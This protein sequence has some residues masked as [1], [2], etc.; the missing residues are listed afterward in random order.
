MKI[1]F[2]VGVAAVSLF[3]APSFAADIP[4]APPVAPA[5][6]GYVPPPPFTWTGVY[7]GVNAGYGWARGSTTATVAGVTF[8]VDNGT[9]RGVIGGGQVGFNWQT[10]P[11]VLGLEADIQ[12]SGQKQTNSATVLGVT[13]TQTDK[14]TSFG[15]VRARVGFA[16]DRWMFYGTAGWA[17]GAFQSDL[18]VTGLGTATLGKGRGSGW[19]AGAGVE[20]AVTNNITV[21]LEYL[22]LD[23]GRVF[24]T[25]SLP[26]VTFTSRGQD[27]IVRLGVNFLFNGR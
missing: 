4:P 21:K 18:T 12:G 20:A 6:K 17:Y 1:G 14:I 19:A 23:T 26:G 13:V 25:T 10:G 2:V 27:E 9:L 24:D 15:T 7:L 22:H 16:A 3:A 11:L 8:P 5:Y